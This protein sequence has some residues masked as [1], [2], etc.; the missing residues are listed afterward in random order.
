MES[1]GTLAETVVDALK[2]NTEVKIYKNKNKRIIVYFLFQVAAQI[3]A[4]RLETKQKKRQMAMQ[5]R[6]RQLTKMG[7][8]LGTSGEVKVGNKRNFKLDTSTCYLAYRI[9]FLAVL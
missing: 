4:V 3:E 1:L 8:Q 5:M 7:M 9:L 2:E 6:Q